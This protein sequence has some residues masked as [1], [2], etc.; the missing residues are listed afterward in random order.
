MDVS[1]YYTVKKRF[2]VTDPDEYPITHILLAR[3]PLFTQSKDKYAHD[4]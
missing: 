1:F 4:M 3:K 2:C